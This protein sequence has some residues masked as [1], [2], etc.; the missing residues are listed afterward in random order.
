MRGI[1]QQHNGWIEVESEV[2][3]GSTFRIYLPVAAS[4]AAAVTVPM[5]PT[6]FAHAT[7]LAVEDDPKLQRLTR[8]LLAREGYSVLEAGD[9]AQALATWA[10]HR[11][12]IDLLYTDMVMPG[13]LSGLQ[14]AQ[15]FQEEK[16]GLKVI[17]TS[18]YNTDHVDL[19]AVAAA[20]IVYLP[21]PC[22]PEV[23]LE[24]IRRILG[25]AREPGG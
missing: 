13:T 22:E 24:T 1:V 14:L 19:E 21:K 18:G 7:I 15:R 16:P 20:S 23:L 11:D 5:V 12:E 6:A 10:A 2:G 8:R 4:E 9:G 25:P 3:R 17:I